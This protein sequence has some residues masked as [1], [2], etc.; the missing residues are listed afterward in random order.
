MKGKKNKFAKG[1][2]EAQEHRGLGL[3]YV[4]SCISH[5]LRKARAFYNEFCCDAITDG[6]DDTTR[7]QG[8]NY[9]VMLVDPYF[10]IPIT[11]FTSH[12]YSTKY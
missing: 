7:R 8:Y 9:E 5:I 3:W 12:D 6:G 10:S 2:S 1:R 11:P 4:T